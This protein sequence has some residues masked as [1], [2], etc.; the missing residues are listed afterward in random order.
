MPLDV[1]FLPFDPWAY[2]VD[3][4]RTIDVIREVKQTIRDLKTSYA[5]VG[6][7]L[8]AAIAARDQLRE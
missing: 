1:R 8:N 4:A 2:N 6:P 5:Q 7:A 3:L